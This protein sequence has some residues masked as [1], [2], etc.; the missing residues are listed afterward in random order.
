MRGNTLDYNEIHDFVYDEDLVEE[1]NQVVDL[2]ED[3]LDYVTQDEVLEA[4]A[5]EPEDLLEI[6]MT[7]HFEDGAAVRIVVQANDK[8]HA[9][10]A[11]Y[12]AGADDYLSQLAASLDGDE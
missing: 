5:G 7:V 1:L 4:L 12:R 2:G 10:A 8:E 3:L 9:L 11:L 6:D